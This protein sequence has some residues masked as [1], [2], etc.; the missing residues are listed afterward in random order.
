MRR[1]FAPVLVVVVSAI[2]LAG[3]AADAAAADEPAPGTSAVETPEAMVE[4]A[5]PTAGEP[6]TSPAPSA[7][8][9]PPYAY[10][11]EVVAPAPYPEP[12]W[13]YPAA[14]V[15]LL[16]VRPVMVA[17]LAGGAALFVGTLPFTAATLTTDDAA[18]ALADQARSTF[19]R[20]L[21]DF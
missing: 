14:A 18:R 6:E 9:Q 10:P 7:L 21:G 17:G 2:T 4:T 20:P 12:P 13:R 5:S 11:E 1:P 8:D 16:L 3:S 15:D 19:A